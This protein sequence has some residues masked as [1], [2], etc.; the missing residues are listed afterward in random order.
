MIKKFENAYSNREGGKGPR[1]RG[2]LNPEKGIMIATIIM[3]YYLNSA[4]KAV[5]TSTLAKS[6]K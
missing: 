6:T 3:N 4:Q 1:R 5:I 2:I